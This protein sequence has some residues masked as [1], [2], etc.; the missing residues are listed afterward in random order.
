M[1]KE[2]YIK[3]QDGAEGIAGGGGITVNDPT[4][5]NPQKINPYKVNVRV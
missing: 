1:R 2:T 3:T 4:T 5:I